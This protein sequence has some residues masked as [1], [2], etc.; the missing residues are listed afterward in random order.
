M[1][2]VFGL[3]GFL[4]LPFWA[5]MIF[6]PRSRWTRRIMESPLVIV[7]P[8]LLYTALVLPVVGEVLPIVNRPSLAAVASLLGSPAGATIGWVHFLAF[9]LFVGRWV[10]LDSR[11]RGISPWIMAPVLYLTLMLGPMGFAL[12]LAVRAVAERSARARGGIAASLR[13]EEA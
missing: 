12:Y 9:D 13:A 5:L 3:S 4:V 6:L 7:A 10:Y 2:R 1:D 11:D 8:A